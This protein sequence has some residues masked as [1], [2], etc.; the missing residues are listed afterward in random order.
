MYEDTAINTAARFGEI[1]FAEFTR[2]LIVDTFNALVSANSQQM[3]EYV[4]Y[5]QSLSMSLTTYL[6]NTIDDVS[7]SEISDFV[8]KLNLPDG[9][10]TAT[11]I[12]AM[13]AA[14]VNMAPTPPA[15]PA[16]PPTTP[17]ASGTVGAIISAAA[18]IV[19]T[20]LGKLVNHGTV[21]PE[22][23]TSS[24]QDQSTL[25]FVNASSTALPNYQVLYKAIAATIGSNK[26][27]LLQNMARMGLMR[28][29]VTDG[30]IE[31][32]I[33]FSTFDNHTDSHEESQSIKEK[34]K[35][36]SA[37]KLGFPM[38][39]NHRTKS[40]RKTVTINTAKNI[41]RDTSGSSVQIFG[42]VLVRF[43]TDFQPLSQS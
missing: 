9:A 23:T 19:Q 7:M 31:T 6:N 32:R 15:S 4:E 22:T 29:V 43:K 5:V 28:L 26:Y 8:S 20:L 13:Q 30:E 37:T 34:T 25:A 36:K 35:D 2:D 12:D 27:A 10:Q 18:P 40:M 38:L 41:H 1:P 16:I 17:I 11:L 24:L 3:H 39:F 42:R 14:Q 21:A 33:T